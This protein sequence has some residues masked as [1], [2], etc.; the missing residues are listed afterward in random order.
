MIKGILFDFNG[1]MVFDGP[2]HKKAWNAFSLKYRDKPITDDE[3]DHLHGLTNKRI[4]EMLMGKGVVSEE[5]SKKLSIA[6]EALY[7]EVCRK[8]PS[9]QLVDGLEEVLNTLKNMQMPM[10]I[11]SASIKDNMDFFISYFQFERWFDVRKIVYD[12][13]L[14][15]DKISMFQDGAKNIGV[16]IEECLVIEDSLSGIAFAHNCHV[17]KIIA[18]TSKDKTEEYKRLPGV[19]AVIHDFNDFD[20]SF[21][22]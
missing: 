11:C 5:E 19:D 3:L 18:I 22:R 2:M 15:P 13:G 21:L 16:P 6:K 7:R 1:T 10:T 12:D 20:S 17:A 14:H 9:Y 4:I 8:D